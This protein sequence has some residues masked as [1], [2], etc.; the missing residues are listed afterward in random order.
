MKCSNL[1]LNIMHLQWVKEHLRVH[2]SET[3]YNQNDRLN[4][5]NYTNFE[6]NRVY[7][8]KNS[9]SLCKNALAVFGKP[10]L[11]QRILK[12][13]IFPPCGTAPEGKHDQRA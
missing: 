7:L 5:D 6:V 10:L 12:N 4:G 8:I 3:T 13:L 11:P 9:C 1:H 2:T